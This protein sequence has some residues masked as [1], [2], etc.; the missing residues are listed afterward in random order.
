[1]EA[2]VVHCCPGDWRWSVA[3][4]RARGKLLDALDLLDL[5]DHQG[6]FFEALA[7]SEGVA[8][9]EQIDPERLD[10]LAARVKVRRNVEGP[11]KVRQE[12]LTWIGAKE[13]EG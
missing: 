12:V 6:G 3:W 1:M 5:L 9:I 8:W 13:Q 11:Q 2:E 10:E 4:M 7:R